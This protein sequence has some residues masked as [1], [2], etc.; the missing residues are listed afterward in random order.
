M[1][2]YRGINRNLLFLLLHHLFLL[3]IHVLIF[4]LLLVLNLLS[5]P[6]DRLLHQAVWNAGPHALLYESSP[7]RRRLIPS[8]RA[9]QALG[10]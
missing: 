9:L 10:S 4:I 6:P 5:P 3:L 7:L 1:N 2:L 8:V